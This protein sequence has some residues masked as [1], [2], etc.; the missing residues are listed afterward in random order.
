MLTKGLIL[1]LLAPLLF[2]PRVE[3]PV[4]DNAAPMPELPMPSVASAEIEAST[5]LPWPDLPAMRAPEEAVAEFLAEMMESCGGE[6]VRFCRLAWSY[7]D[8]RRG[9][10]TS[11]DCAGY[12]PRPW[13]PLKSK[14]L[15]QLLCA[16]GCERVQR[17]MRAS[18]E[19]RPTF[20]IIPAS[21][22]V[23]DAEDFAEP[24]RLAA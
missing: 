24:L 6:A 22:D 20:I 14:T 8:M 10:A 15:S 11:D 21:A 3:R 17:D 19:G 2:K 7:E 4:N 9:R 23:E 16:L 12:A 1:G 5:S 13:P 18:G